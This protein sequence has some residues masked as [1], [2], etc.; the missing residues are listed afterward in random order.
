MNSELLNYEE[1]VRKAKLS[2]EEELVNE[3]FTRVCGKY[4]AGTGEFRELNKALKDI[5]FSNERYEFLYLLSKKLWKILR[6]DR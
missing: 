3:V 2:A 4:E 5:T 6:Y 1:K